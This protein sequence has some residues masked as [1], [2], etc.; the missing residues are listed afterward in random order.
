[1]KKVYPM[2]PNVFYQ[3]YE[4]TRVCVRGFDWGKQDGICSLLVGRGF[5]VELA[6]PSGGSDGAIIEAMMVGDCLNDQ[7]AA[8]L[9][10]AVWARDSGSEAVRHR[11]LVQVADQRRPG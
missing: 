6:D 2:T 11:Q 10:Q 3:H 8:G 4:G 7:E 1:M 9:A 5:E